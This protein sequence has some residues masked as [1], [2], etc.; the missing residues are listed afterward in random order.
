MTIFVKTSISTYSVLRIGVSVTVERSHTTIGLSLNLRVSVLH[1]ERLIP[2]LYQEPLY[3]GFVAK[4]VKLSSLT[5]VR[6]DNPNP[7]C[8]E[9]EWKGC[10]YGRWE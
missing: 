4:S 9:Q 2:S 1:E 3:K 5:S 6:E 7:I 10:G 8:L